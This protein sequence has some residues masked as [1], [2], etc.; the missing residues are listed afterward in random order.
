MIKTFKVRLE[1]NNKQN[2]KL[3]Q[4]SGT[5]RWVYNWA[6]GRQRDNYKLGNKFISDGELRKEIT[7]L[8]KTEEF[9]WL[10]SV[11][12]NIAKQAIKDAC[13]AYVKFFKKQTEFP[14]FKSKKKSKNSFYQD[15]CKIKFDKEKIRVE[16]IGWI[17]LSEK[18]RIPIDTKYYNPRI[19][20][21]GLH[22][23][24]SVGVEYEADISINKKEVIGIDLGVK[25]LAVCSNGSIYG[26]INKT[27]K[28][29]K[30]RKKLKRL[31]RKVSNKYHKNKK[32]ESYCK[33]SNIIKLE[34][35]I[36]KLHNRIWNIKRDYMNKVTTEIVKNKP[37]KI[38]ME[39]LN[40]KGMIK[41][42]CLSD[43]IQNQSLYE[44]KRQIEYKCMFNNIE[45]IS[46]DR[47]F[48]SSK[49]CSECGSVKKDLKLSNRTYICGECGCII[50]RDL[51]ASIN[52]C[53]YGMA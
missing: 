6:I 33:T 4:S 53:K 42:R 51:N 17:R 45:F 34:N 49:I 18:N 2:T 5:A 43:A 48:P 11:S 3:F 29:K 50:D 21:D 12:N 27:D 52:L 9:N 10:R 20:Y 28:I 23:Y 13:D 26:N 41:N 47:W 38:V 8:K 32:G 31:Q 36:K 25:E 7:L 46:A 37:S 39:T 15:N 24:I 1:P 44:F 22:W 40:I 30:L 14:Q 16:K 19:S 35:N